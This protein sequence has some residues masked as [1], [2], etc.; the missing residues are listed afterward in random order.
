MIAAM[1][2]RLLGPLVVPECQR[3]VGRTRSLVF[4]TVGAFCFSLIALCIIW[5]WWAVTE[6]KESAV[7]PYG[8]LRIGLTITL[9]LG[10]AIGLL[11]APATL[12]GAI[13]GERE[14]VS[15]GLL[16][17]T[18]V[19]SFE[20]MTGRLIGK[21]SQVILVL[22]TGIPCLVFLGALAGIRVGP[23]LMMIFYPVLL[24]LGA[25][26]LTAG[27]SSMTR[28][29]RDTL[30]GAYLIGM[31]ICAIPVLNAWMPPYGS[32]NLWLERANPFTAVGPL[33]YDE[34]PVP[35]LQSSL[36]W[37]TIGLVGTSRAISTLRPNILRW[38][39]GDPPRRRRKAT[40]RVR[41]R[42]PVNN[43]PM[44]WKEI[45]A[46][47]TSKGARVVQVLG[48]SAISY[49]MITSLSQFGRYFYFLLWE[50][51]VRLA[52]DAQFWMQSFI[53]DT[54]IYFSILIQWAVG[55]RAAVLIS[56]ERDQGTWDALLA[57]PLSGREIVLG[58]VL[59]SLHAL[60]WLIIATLLA[61]TLALVCGAMSI[62]NFVYNILWMLVSAGFMAAV[63]V[64]TSLSRSSTTSA[65][66]FTIGAWLAAL[67]LLSIVAGV[68][69]GIIS[70][71]WLIVRTTATNLGIQTIV[72][73]P[74]TREVIFAVSQLIMYAILAQL[75]VLETQLRFDRLAGR[76]L[77]GGLGLKLDR[78]IHGEAKEPVLLDHANP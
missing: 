1:V 43:A 35:A 39:D 17:T 37:L 12:A 51:N 69:V 40:R 21:F 22:S 62:W 44:I 48:I 60:R 41:K 73:P 5:W 14:R 32:I 42:P 38:L 72:F 71:T 59:G 7:S 27:V 15:I 78:V 33:V 53:T 3:S 16:L 64:R 46:D 67:V 31:G 13:N 34:N 47:R 36:I 76:L 4:R 63:G 18:L 54:A 55:L 68:F 75:L 70:L 29:G 20:V 50:S 6:S 45:F 28:R 58:K 8:G 19:N 30:L 77:D 61:W 2:T 56:S 11:L 49:L 25:S 24:G 57:S 10:V 74:G 23:L 52:D 26:G 9:G 65:M 66:S